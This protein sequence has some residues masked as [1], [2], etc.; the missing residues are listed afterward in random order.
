MSRNLSR[1]CRQRC[2][3]MKTLSNCGISKE[4]LPPFLLICNFG[5]HLCYIFQSHISTKTVIIRVPITWTLYLIGTWFREKN[6]EIKDPRKKILAKFN[7]HTKNSNC[8]KKWFICNGN[9]IYRIF[10]NETQNINWFLNVNSIIIIFNACIVIVKL[11]LNSNN[12]FFFKCEQHF[13]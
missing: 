8:R 3:K 1:F 12:K 9:K 11:V 13:A 10:I 6:C 2:R 7:T 4:A 5:K